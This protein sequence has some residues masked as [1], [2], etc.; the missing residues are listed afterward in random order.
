MYHGTAITGDH[1]NPVLLTTLEEFVDKYGDHGPEGSPTWKYVAGILSSGLPVIF[2]RIAVENQDIGDNELI[3]DINTDDEEFNADEISTVI[4]A[5][6][7]ISHTVIDDT[8]TEPETPP[9]VPDTGTEGAGDTEVTVAE[10]D[11]DNTGT[12]DTTEPAGTKEI[13]D[14][15]VKEKF[16]GTYGNNMYITIRRSSTA[17]WL[18]VIQGTNLLERKRLA[19]ID[20]VNDDTLSI[21]KKVYDTLKNTEFERIIITNIQE[22]LSLMDIQSKSR[23]RLSGG[24]D[25]PEAKVRAEIP[26]SYKYIYDKM[27]YQPLFITSGGYTDDIASSGGTY[28]IASAMKTISE[29]RQDCMAVIDI[30]PFSSQEEYTEA[31]AMLSYAQ[32]TS[33]SVIPSA[34]LYG[35]WCY[36]QVGNSQDWMPP[37]YAYL[38]TMGYRISEGKKPYNPVAGLSTGIVNNIIKT[39]F[40]IGSDVAESWQSDTE[41]NIN[42]IMKMNGSS[43]VLGGNST[44]LVPEEETGENNLFVESSA[45]LTVI[46]IR[47]SIYEIAAG[48]QFQYNS[49]TAFEDFGLRASTLLDRMITE[50]A[51]SNYA[52]YNLSSDKEPRKMKIRLDVYVTPTVK[53]IEIFLNVGYGSVE[54][55]SV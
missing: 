48:L 54:V 4:R 23:V 18:D 39:E 28:P 50:G 32:E 41:V 53:K 51:V 14:F 47:R 24:L 26:H 5:S 42:P 40:E 37:S 38:T 1:R 52:I 15:V 25:F 7:T 10:G 45:T 11:T 9:T 29:T 12:T 20:T 30:E 19:I 35:P 46:E 31:A 34:S 43:Y 36:M 44:L 16:G 13:V 2:R 3:D 22:D 17:I 8:A 33:S 55:T 6:A 21:N 49:A 27:L